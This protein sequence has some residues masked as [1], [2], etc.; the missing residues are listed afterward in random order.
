MNIDKHIEE[1]RDLERHSDAVYK[2]SLTA[3]L[4]LYVSLFLAA[5]ENHRL[6]AVCVTFC[7]AVC[8]RLVLRAR[9]VRVEGRLLRQIKQ[10]VAEQRP[11]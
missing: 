11:L 8:L 7:L 4:L 10:N 2:I 5:F 1:I 6:L 9:D 3:G